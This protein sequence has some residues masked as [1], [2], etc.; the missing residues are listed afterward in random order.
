MRPRLATGVVVLFAFFLAPVGAHSTTLSDLFSTNGTFT[1]GNLL[2]SNFKNELPNL[3]PPDSTVLSVSVSGN[4]GIDLQVSSLFLSG[5]PVTYAFSYTVTVTDPNF[6]IHDFT[7][8]W[9]PA[10]TGSGFLR[11]ED[12]VLGNSVLNT[13]PSGSLTGNAIFFP[14]SSLRILRY[15]QFQ[16]SLYSVIAP[17]DSISTFSE[18]AAVPEPTSLL[19]LGSGLAGLAAWRRKMA[20]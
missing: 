3:T 11:V 18:V 15:L 17:V 6:L 9:S 2:F 13:W 7:S 16:G 14:V 5:G 19:L 12:V 10:P 8:S 1:S 20:A 4:P